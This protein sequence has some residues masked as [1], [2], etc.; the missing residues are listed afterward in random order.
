LNVQN[1]PFLGKP[2]P[3]VLA[4]SMV[5]ASPFVGLSASAQAQTSASATTSYSIAAGPLDQTLRRIEGASGQAVAFDTARARSLVSAPVKGELTAE[6]AVRAALVG[7]GLTLGVKPDGALL[8]SDAVGPAPAPAEHELPVTSLKAITVVAQR[9]QAETSFKVDRTSTSTRSDTDLMD[10]PSSVTVITS[11]VL[12]S[13]QATS[14]KDAISQVAGVIYTQSPQGAP[15]FAIRGFGQTSVLSNGLQSNAA[16][17]ANVSG[18]ERI[19]VLKGPQAILSGAG[20]LGGAVNIVTKKPQAEPIRELTTQYGSHDDMLAAIDLSGAV[21]QDKKLTYRLIVSRDEQSKNAAGFDG[22][23][24]EFYMPELRWKDN[25]TDVIVGY[26]ADNS[27]NGPPAYTFA[28]LDHVQQMPTQRLG[29]ESD[30]FDNQAQNYFYTWTQ[31]ISPDLKFTSKMQRTDNQF[32]LHMKSPLGL[33]GPD[34]IFYAQSQQETQTKT[35]AGDHYFEFN[36]NTGP[37]THKLTTGISHEKTSISMLEFY[38]DG[39]PVAVYGDPYDFTASN[40]TPYS[41]NLNDGKQ[42]GGYALDL[43]KW[44]DVSILLGGRRSK[45]QAESS[46]RNLSRGRLSKTP[47]E[48]IWETTPMVGVVYSVTP[49]VSVYANYVDGFNPQLGKTM[50]GGVPNEPMRTKNKEAGAKFDFFGSKFSVT[51]AMFELDQS[52][53]L[54]YNSAQ[55]CYNLIS[56]QTTKGIELDMAGQVYEG[57]NLLFNAT[58]STLKD[59][60]GETLVFAAHPTQRASLWATYDFQSEALRGWGM[61]LGIAANN[62]SY[63]GTKYATSTTDPVKLPGSARVDASV[64]YRSKDWS[65]VL[66]VKNL[67]DRELYD[68]AT[69]TTYVPVQPSRTTTLTYKV[70]F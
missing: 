29:H 10:V 50:C 28:Y 52:N 18:V 69:T 11:K 70:N 40:G 38:E 49:T 35:T 41:L 53:V 47:S 43:M 32:A 6:A 4:L 62:K 56:A 1:R 37:V 2:L 64:S 67:L 39:M 54:S 57:L 51:T 66:G 8:V 17:A 7:T 13:Q 60:S 24:A 12:E 15:E 34:T 21:S 48:S 14:V 25:T 16:S 9:D 20:S 61:G 59:V 3:L 42:V 27:H 19:E 45:Y 33:A 36:F 31:K 22:N 46:V 23:K 68:F 58:Y 44:G 63:L 30:G 26:S 65:L 55:K 5:Y